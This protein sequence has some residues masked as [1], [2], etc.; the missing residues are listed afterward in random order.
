MKAII[1][2]NVTG[3]P[4]YVIVKNTREELDQ[5]IQY[6]LNKPNCPWGQ[7]E[8]FT[9]EILEEVDSTHTRLV[10]SEEM[11][12]RYQL[13]MELCKKVEAYYQSIIAARGLSKPKRKKL[14][15]N[16]DVKAILEELRFGDLKEAARLINKVVE[17][18]ELFFES[19]LKKVSQFIKD[20]I[21]VYK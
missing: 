4:P 7:E 19:D 17:D 11:L 9:I 21:E 8:D 5:F 1:T 6:Q 20:L 18:K 15:K 16:K 3:K 13:N 12:K 14:R 2:N 10:K